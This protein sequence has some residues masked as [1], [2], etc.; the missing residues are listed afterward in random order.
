MKWHGAKPF[1][2]QVYA[3]SKRVSNDDAVFAAYLLVYLFPDLLYRIR[4]ADL[5]CYTR[6]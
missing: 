5:Y 2:E 6:L 3:P 1:I 4:N